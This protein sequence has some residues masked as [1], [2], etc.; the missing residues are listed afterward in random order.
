[1][2]EKKLTLAE[3]V[4]EWNSDSKYVE[5]YTSGSTGT[6]KRMLV[7]K[8]RMAESARMTCR[9][10]SLLSSDT[11]LLCMPLE[12][13]A[14]KMVVV[15]CLVSG[16]RLTQVEPSGHPLKDIDNVP[17]FVAMVPMQVYNTLQVEEEAKKLRA[18]KNLII[19]GGAVDSSLERQL[20]DFPNAVWSTYGMTET[21]SHIAMRRINGL[22]ASD[23]YFPLPGVSLSVD[24]RGCLVVS[25]PRICKDVLYTRDIVELDSSTGAFKVL[26]R[27]DNVI[28]SGGIKIQTED[29]ENA[30]RS[31]TDINFAISKQPD[32]KFGE[33]VV[34]AVEQSCGEEA[35]VALKDKIEEALPKY[36]HP[37][38]YCLIEKIPMTQTGKIARKELFRLLNTP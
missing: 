22:D 15:R 1:M 23:Y 28:C 14:G 26:G 5:V 20:K 8:A 4:S 30:V 35:L 2:G 10:L 19:G 12:Y 27:M 25:A 7:E 9:F 11:A 36:W 21:L 24:K 31:L 3:F 37:K 6:P 17:S 32:E 33:I 13:I 38:R 18:V 16:M 29:V 34:M